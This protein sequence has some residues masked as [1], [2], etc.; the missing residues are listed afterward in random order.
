MI[1]VTSEPR[2]ENDQMKELTLAQILTTYV[3]RLRRLEKI[4]PLLHDLSVENE[5]TINAILDADED[6]LIQ[7][8]QKA[9]PT[10]YRV[11]S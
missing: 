10:I 11:T 5:D 3:Q 1:T 8:I 7:M 4:R 6:K 2:S 9:C